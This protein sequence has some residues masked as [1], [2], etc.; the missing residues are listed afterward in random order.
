[1]LARWAS[2]SASE[3]TTSK[4]A[5]TREAVTLACW[6]PGPEERLV[7]SSISASGIARSG[8]IC[9]VAGT[10]P[11]LA[12]ARCATLAGVDAQLKGLA[13]VS[14]CLDEAEAALGDARHVAAVAALD[15]AEDGLARLR[16]AWPELPPV[17]R[18][19]V[20][21]AGAQARERLEALRG[22]LPARRALTEA[23]PTPDPSAA[24][25]AVP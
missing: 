2:V 14:G 6:P 13:D 17:A 9:R 16:A 7:R 19:V 1:M 5:S 15:Q 10:Q 21:P 18:R 11:I 24:S 20:G 12:G 8:V 23:P 3:A 25:E 4:L 22:R